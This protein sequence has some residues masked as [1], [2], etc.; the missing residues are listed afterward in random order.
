MRSPTVSRLYLQCAPDEDLARWPD[1]RIWQ[2]LATRL[3]SDAGFK[4]TTGPIVQKNVAPMRSFVTEPMQCG[5]LFLSGDAAHIVP[6]TGAKGMNL[7]VSD[8]YVLAR[9]LAHHYRTGKL[10]QLEAYS[11]ICLRRIWKVQRF[12]WW[13]TS[14]LHKFD[15]HNAFDRRR[16]LA[17]LDYFT[18]SQAA[19]LALAENYVGLPLEL[20]YV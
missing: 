15:D 9:A 18:S 20:P 4:L 16:Q 19:E 2:E 13:M 1:E 7:A 17:E 6:P 11:A 8:V 10:D 14:M 5:R 3:A 12:S